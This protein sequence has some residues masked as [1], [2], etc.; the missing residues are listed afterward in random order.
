MASQWESI[1][2]MSNLI[3]VL[4]LW[5]SFFHVL[6]VWV[7]F[8]SIIGNLNLNLQYFRTLS[9]YM[10]RK[11]QLQTQTEQSRL[12]NQK[13]KVIPDVVYNKPSQ[14]PEDTPGEDELEVTPFKDKAEQNGVPK[15]VPVETCTPRGYPTKITAGLPILLFPLLVLC[16][17]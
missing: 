5:F 7:R 3:L 14:D 17:S 10:D 11:L 2:I 13:P 9:E 6:G 8:T 1:T 15:F 4:C 16:N 12:L